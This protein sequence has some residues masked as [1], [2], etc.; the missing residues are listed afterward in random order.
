MSLNLPRAALLAFLLL[1]N[2]AA[3]A[4]AP[5]P[6]HPIRLIAPFP[7]GGSSDVLGRIL[8]Q[9]LS[10]T[11]GQQL[12]VENHPGAA[13]NIGHELAAKSTPDGYTLVLSNSSVLTTNIHLYKRLGFDPQNDFAPISMV[14]T[15]GQVLVVHPSV[16]AKSVAELIA[17]AKARPGKLNFGSGG[18]GITSHISGELFKTAARVDI[19]HVPYKGTVQ[20]VTDLVAG[21]LDMVFADMIP[22]IPQIKGGKLRPLAVTSLKRSAVLPEV[23]TMIEA[24]VKGYESGVW[25]ALL[26]PRGTPE[27]I[28]TRINGDL[29]RVMKMPAVIDKYSGL[30]IFTAH[31]TPQ[32]VS[33]RIRV[34]TPEM[35]RIL[36]AAGVQPE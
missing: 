21:Q 14:A 3:L 19:V 34:E 2:G 1:L 30:G 15:A 36:K 28:V 29:E 7:P 20:A 33:E 27:A 16:P 12:V 8:A 25:W 5:Y 13:A 11:L 9:R 10:E 4:Q 31:S 32:A 17:L 6:T 18:V 23:P 24:G 26:A 22:A 35:G